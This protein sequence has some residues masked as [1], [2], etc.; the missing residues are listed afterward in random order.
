MRHCIDTV[1]GVDVD[2]SSGVIAILGVAGQNRCTVNF[3]ST[4]LQDI[5]EASIR[6]EEAGYLLEDDFQ[7]EMPLLVPESVTVEAAHEMGLVFRFHLPDGKQAAFIIP[8]SIPFDQLDK[9]ARAVSSGIHMADD[10]GPANP[11]N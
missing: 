4:A 3:P 6:A 11:E 5:L 1:T 2:P 7:V 9:A 8:A 10:G